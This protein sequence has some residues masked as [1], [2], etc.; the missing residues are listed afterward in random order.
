MATAIVPDPARPAG[1]RDDQVYF[2]RFAK[3]MLLLVVVAFAQWSARGFVVFGAVPV[4]VHVHGLAMLSWFG[5]FVAQNWLA[6]NGNL[7]LH[8]K[9]GWLGLALLALLVVLGSFTTVKAVEL[10]RVPSIFT[11]GYFLALGTVGWPIV[12]ALVSAAVVR[13]R[14]TE[15]HRRLM[16]SAYI[17]LLEPAF[18][19]LLPM[20]LLGAAGPWVEMLCQFGVFGIAMAHDR[21]VRGTVHP[22]YWWGMAGLLAMYVVIHV[23]SG[24]SAFNSFAEAIA[25]G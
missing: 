20:P 9:L 2:L 1:W 14:E 15:L 22:A 13:R 24:M 21:K 18:G 16:L 6:A 8:R 23:L 12:I 25:A 7:V 11:N 5:L 3:A 10:N 19:R 4:W 17:L